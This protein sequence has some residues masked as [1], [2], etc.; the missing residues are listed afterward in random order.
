[1]IMTLG[2][3]RFWSIYLVTVLIW[4]TLLNSGCIQVMLYGMSAISSPGFGLRL[5][6]LRPNLKSL[7]SPA[8]GGNSNEPHPDWGVESELRRVHQLI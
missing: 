2:D 1:M 6:L 5:G 3:R 7:P 8:R 4:G